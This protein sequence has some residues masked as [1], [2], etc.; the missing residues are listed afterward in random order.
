M[1]KKLNGF[2]LAEVLITLGIIGVVA[3]M[4]IPTLIKNTQNAEY[5][6]AAKKAFSNLSNATNLI[7]NDNSGD[8]S[9]V[10]SYS[11]VVDL[12]AE[13]MKVIKKCSNSRTEG[14]W[15]YDCLTGPNVLQAA[16][17]GMILNDG[18]MVT[19]FFYDVGCNYAHGHAVIGGTN[20]P[21]N[22]ADVYVDT[23]GAKPP[24]YIGKDILVFLLYK[25]RLRVGATNRDYMELHP[26]SYNC[27]TGLNPVMCQLDLFK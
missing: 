15:T 10:F 13:K 21:N 20:S 3:T 7:V 11:N 22:C 5:A 24:S 25:D 27:A 2:T 23:N 9:N 18:T 8:L 14:C 17:S 4:T 12:Y 6:S 19:F 1:Y 26:A 16:K